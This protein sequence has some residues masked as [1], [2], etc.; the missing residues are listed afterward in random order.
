MNL[1]YKIMRYT[2]LEKLLHTQFRI[3]AIENKQSSDILDTFRQFNSLTGIPVYVW[4]KDKGLYRLDLSEVKIPQTID[5]QHLI[6]YMINHKSDSIFILT[7]FA[8]QLNHTF[9]ENRLI[10]ITKG[11]SK[12]KIIILD[13]K[14]DL[15][16]K[17][18]GLALETK[19]LFKMKLQRAA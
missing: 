19:N 10:N 8:G 7:G 1:E 2:T 3:I 17:F 14:L 18:K 6:N 11:N 4:K 12:M 5:L 15:S 9:V 16:R 13:Q